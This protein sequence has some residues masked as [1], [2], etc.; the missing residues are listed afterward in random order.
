MMNSRGTVLGWTYWPWLDCGN[1]I[2]CTYPATV[3]NVSNYD[4]TIVEVLSKIVTASRN[5]LT[6]FSTN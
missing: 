5:E 6:R 4:A 1:S 3:P 2:R